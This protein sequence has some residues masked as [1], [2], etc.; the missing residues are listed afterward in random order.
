MQKKVYLFSTSSHADA[1]SINSLDIKLLKPEIDF[2]KYDYLII[3]SKQVSNALSQYE[4]AEYIEKKALC[5]ST[6]SAKSFEELGG[7]VLSLGSG[8]GD[9]LS[10]IIKSHPKDIKWLYLRAKVVASDFTKECL[11]DGYN[12]DEVIV[13]ES[14]CSQ[15][16]KN[17]CVSQNDTLIFT[18]PSSIKCFLKYHKISKTNDVIVIGRSSAKAIPKHIEYKISQET[19]IKS[20][21]ELLH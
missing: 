3:T 1:I 16:I 7:K 10:S 13:Y 12:I 14:E 8:Y 11:S 9:N 4:R 5:I 21:M 19:T 18:S 15:D 2:S 20:C 17:V 6:Q